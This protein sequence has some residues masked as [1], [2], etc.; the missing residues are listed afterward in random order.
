MGALRPRGAGGRCVVTGRYATESLRTGDTIVSVAS[1]AS[2][3]YYSDTVT[4]RQHLGAGVYHLHALPVFEGGE[5]L[6]MQW[7]V[8]MC[9]TKSTPEREKA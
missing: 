5:K 6:V 7:G 2:V 4:I 1:S 8:G 9:T 3:L